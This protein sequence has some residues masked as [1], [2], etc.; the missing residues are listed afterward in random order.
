MRRSLELRGEVAKLQPLHDRAGQ[1]I[2]L[3]RHDRGF[4][5]GR[6]EAQQIFL[7]GLELLD[8]I[9][10]RS[11]R[12]IADDGRL[13]DEARHVV[14]DRAPAQQEV[15]GLVH[16]D[17]AEGDVDPQIHEQRVERRDARKDLDVE[18]EVRSGPR[19]QRRR[20][21]VDPRMPV[22]REAHWGVGYRGR[23]DLSGH[24]PVGGQAVLAGLVEGAELRHLRTQRRQVLRDSVSRVDDERAL[25]AADDLLRLAG[26]L[27]RPDDAGADDPDVER[28]D[29]LNGRLGFAQPISSINRRTAPLRSS[30]VLA[31]LIASTSVATFASRPTSSIVVF[32]GRVRLTQS[33]VPEI[34]IVM[35]GSRL[36]S[37]PPLSRPASFS[38]S[39]NVDRSSGLRS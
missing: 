37:I 1:R 32:F 26:E 17:A 12:R 4:V 36:T 9:G 2:R 39:L 13:P 3:G 11:I 7:E 18:A 35:L 33:C 21:A 15:G 27:V 20:I 14:L 6:V 5:I 22:C 34:L 10:L 25:A 16:L 28:P 30:S 24:P 38:G 19:D 31:F 29:R 23:D 8:R